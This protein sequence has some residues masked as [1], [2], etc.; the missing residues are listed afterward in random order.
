MILTFRELGIHQPD[1][2]GWTVWQITTDVI[3]RAADYYKTM[4][5]YSEKDLDEN[6]FLHYNWPV[7]LVLGEIEIPFDALILDSDLLEPTI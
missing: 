6:F 1:Y 3:N 5:G 7:N 2:N 4:L